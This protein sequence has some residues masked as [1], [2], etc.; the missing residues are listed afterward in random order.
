MLRA[1]SS[2]SSGIGRLRERFGAPA[3]ALAVATLAGV[4]SWGAGCASGTET[5]LANTAPGTGTTTTT[6]TT[7]T[8][9]ISSGSTSGSTSMSSSSSSSS[10]SSGSSSSNSSSSNSSSSSGGQGGG[11][12]GGGGQGG[13]GQGGGASGTA[14]LLGGSPATIF[15]GAFHPGAPWTTSSLADAT[16]S[17]VALATTSQG[18]GVGLVRSTSN[19]GELRFTTWLA[20]AWAPLTA[21]AAGVTTRDGPAV[22]SLGAAA[23]VVFQGDNF[24]HYFASFAVAW[25]PV[26]DPLGGAGGGSAQSFGPTPPAL[27][28][29][30]ASD[31]AAFVG[32]DHDL[33]DQTRSGGVWQAALGH[34][35]A[36]LVTL[37]PAIVPLTSGPEL[38]MVAVRTDTSIVWTTRTGAAWT[39]L[40]P[41]AIPSALT[42]DR[43]ALTTLP[44]GA[45]LL[46]FRGT[47]GQLFT[48]R[49]TPG[50][51]PT[52]SAP[53]GVAMPNVT[54]TGSPSLAP[55]V[56]GVDAELAFVGGGSGA[57]FHTRL[58]GSTWSAPAM[59][60]GSG[61]TSVAIATMP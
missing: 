5:Q 41:A 45:A 4:A 40:V 61:L 26:A 11:G 15:T 18:K 43:V 54:I 38:L 48:S 30:V 50:P 21:I 6:T 32:N 46:A 56:G 7:T 8:M 37:T 29:L 20:G 23:H 19:G 13:N 51:P 27:A 60:G 33:Y 9:T 31:V 17:G 57:A 53:V 12:Q 1:P 55:G 44:G 49:F 24:K 59:V 22:V 47:N 39:P 35:L 42:A 52:W 28:A 10:T 58:T 34:G 3:L 25:S 16:A 14:L 2:P 36:G